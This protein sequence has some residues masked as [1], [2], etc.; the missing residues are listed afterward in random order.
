MG[1]FPGATLWK[2]TCTAGGHITSPVHAQGP[3]VWKGLV[4]LGHGGRGVHSM[5]KIQ[6]EAEE[7]EKWAGLQAKDSLCFLLLPL[8]HTK[9]LWV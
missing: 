6:W 1:F 7:K 9:L 8:S 3:A 4:G 5:Y 2:E